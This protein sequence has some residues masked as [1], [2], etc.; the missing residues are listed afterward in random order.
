MAFVGAFLFHIHILFFS[1]TDILVC[2]GNQ[3]LTG[4]YG[5]NLRVW[6]IVGVGEMK[7]PGEQYNV[8]TGGLTMEDEMNLDGAVV[9]AAFDE[10]MDMVSHIEFHRC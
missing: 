10:G 5:K 3:L 4:S 7:L 1:C 8:R 2:R 9:S 6:S